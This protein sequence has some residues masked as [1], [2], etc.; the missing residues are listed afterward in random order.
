MKP[1][2]TGGGIIIT[3]LLICLCI[4]VIDTVTVSWIRSSAEQTTEQGVLLNNIVSLPD[5]VTGLI[6]Q[7][8]SWD[9]DELRVFS[10]PESYPN[11]IASGEKGGVDFIAY[12]RVE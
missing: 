1:I 7:L 6:D 9:Q 4:L 2:M 12:R 5:D 10:Q 8:N 3:V 11:R